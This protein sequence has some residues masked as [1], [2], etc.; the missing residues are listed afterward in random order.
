MSIH[1]LIKKIASTLDCRLL[2]VDG[3]PTIDEKHQLPRDVSEFYEQCGGAVLYENADYPIYIVQPTEFKLANPVIVGEL[4]EEDISSEWYIVC[5]DGKGEYLT[6]DLN[7]DRK[8]KCYD[9]FFDR[10]GIV[11]ETQ[12]IATSFTDLIQRL[13][14][15]KGRHW[16]WL[17]GE[18]IS[19][20]DAYDGVEIE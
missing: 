9:S 18:F 5:T 3:L 10:H 1:M 12:V 14:E 8:G 6:I 13:L 11:G 20:G 2:E 4:C 16:Y 17:R 19:L 7:E 15:N